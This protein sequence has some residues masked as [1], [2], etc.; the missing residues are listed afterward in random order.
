MK[1]LFLS[2]IFAS[3]LVTTAM[4][5]PAAAEGNTSRGG[6]FLQ[7]L[8]WVKSLQNHAGEHEKAN[9]ALQAAQHKQT[10]GRIAV[11]DSPRPEGTTASTAD[12]EAQN[13]VSRGHGPGSLAGHP[14]PG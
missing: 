12:G 7:L 10:A 13:E 14:A 3:L 11:D 2:V 4:P 6:P 9:S 5:G 1:Y 8:I